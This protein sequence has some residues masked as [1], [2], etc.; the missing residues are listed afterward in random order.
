MGILG[1]TTFVNCNP[2][3]TEEF[4]LHSTRVVI[5]GNS[6]YHFIFEDTRMD[7]YHGGDYDQY[8]FEI[9]EFFRLL[10]SCNIELYVV[11]DGGTCNDPND[12]K[13]QTI[14]KRMKQ[15]LE[16]AMRIASGLRGKKR[17]MPILAFD[18]FKAVLKKLSIPFA[19]CDFEADKEIAMLANTLNCPVLSNDSDF[20]IFPLTGGFISFDKVIFSLQEIKGENNSVEHFLPARLYHVDNFFPSFGK[21]VLPLLAALLGNDYID[22]DVFK[23]FNDSIQSNECKTQDWKSPGDKRTLKVVLWLQGLNSYSEGRKEIMSKA[24]SQNEKTISSALETIIETFQANVPETESSLYSYFMGKEQIGENRIRGV[25]GSVIPMWYLSHHRKGLL[26]PNCLDIITLHRKFLSPQV[27]DQNSLASSYQSSVN[28]RKYM[29]G[30][31][32]SEDSADFE[33]N[34][35]WGL[36]AN[37]KSVVKEFDRRGDIIISQVINPVK[38]ETYSGKSI[39]LSDIPDLSRNEKKNLLRMILDIPCFNIDHM[40]PDL[41]LILGLV[42]FWIKNSQQKITISHMQSVLVCLIMLKVK[43]ALMYPASIGCDKNLIEAAV[44]GIKTKTLKIVNEKLYKYSKY[45]KSRTSRVD[46]GLIHGFAQF[47]TCIL[48]TMHLNSL[49]LDPFPGPYIP[50]IFSGT[51]LFY[52]TFA[53]N[54][55]EEEILINLY[56]KCYQRIQIFYRFINASLMLSIKL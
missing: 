7:F 31:L 42:I 50:H 1:L 9:T 38:L 4:P 51:F 23:S 10:H 20:F 28:L 17:V 33:T 16:N 2:Q 56:M 22:K 37:M 11:F 24:G 40:T 29:Y 55:I 53:K 8:A 15:K 41:E 26:S 3:L 30:I 27:E 47:Q 46:C 21:E 19:V 18:T 44:F 39:K 5:D 12:M 25:N 48:A 54:S 43:W 13:F 34:G 45:T 32:L 52:I 6:L 35:A 49:L 14:Q 36:Q